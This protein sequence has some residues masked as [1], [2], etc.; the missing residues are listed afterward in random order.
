MGYET[1]MI[2]GEITPFTKYVEVIAVVVLCCLGSNGLLSSLASNSLKKEESEG[3]YWFDWD[4]N[5]KIE[6]DGYGHFPTPVDL[7]D[8][9]TAFKIDIKQSDYRRI[10]WAYDLL[11]S[12]AKTEKERLGSNPTRTK[13]FFFGH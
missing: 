13:V 12:I 5:T 4:G 9:I 1:K 7:E 2:V 8:A 11:R 6:S 3:W 10:R